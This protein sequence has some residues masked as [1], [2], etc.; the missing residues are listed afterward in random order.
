MLIL[1]VDFI[2]KEN[3]EVSFKFE[4]ENMGGEDI[5]MVS[6]ISR[7]KEIVFEKPAAK[8]IIKIENL[9]RKIIREGIFDPKTHYNG[10]FQKE[11]LSL[12]SQQIF[13]F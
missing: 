5:A 2:V 4:G 11:A 8:I 9:Q 7:V 12:V 10:K 6:A 1:E 13:K 3:N